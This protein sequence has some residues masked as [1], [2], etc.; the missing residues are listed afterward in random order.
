MASSL[1]QAGTFTKTVEDAVILSEYL[2]SY[3]PNDATSI[4]RK[5]I[6]NWKK[7]LE[8]ED[9]S[10]LKIAMVKEFFQE[11]LDEE[12]KEKILQASEKIKELG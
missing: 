2:A 5:D 3:D 8:K 11:G 1:D 6:Q 7:A 12:V 4:N 10:G 9:L